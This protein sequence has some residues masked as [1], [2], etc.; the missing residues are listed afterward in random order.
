MYPSLLLHAVSNCYVFC[1]YEFQWLAHVFVV[2]SSQNGSQS[3]IW[4]VMMVTLQAT[5]TMNGPETWPLLLSN[6][7][8]TLH[9]GVLCILVDCLIM[10]PTAS[11]LSV[12]Q[13]TFL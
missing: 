10:H 7:L 2:D 5:R 13:P 3:A 4:Y 12:S 11:P 6:F 8:M 9:I 1:I